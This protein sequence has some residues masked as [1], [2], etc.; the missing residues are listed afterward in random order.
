LYDETINNKK[1]VYRTIKILYNPPILVFNFKRWINHNK[2]N[3]QNIFFDQTID[4]GPYSI[5]TCIYEL[6]AIINHDG[7]L[8]GGHYYTFVKKNTKWLYIN[9]NEIKIISPESINKKTN[10]CLFYRKLK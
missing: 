7:N 10:Y 2:K 1:N 3:T 6:F 8:F 4:M 5:D 9:D